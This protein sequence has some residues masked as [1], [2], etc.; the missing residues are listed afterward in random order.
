MKVA[1]SIFTVNCRVSIRP[2]SN[3][4]VENKIYRQI[5]IAFTFHYQED[6][7]MKKAQ[8][9]KALTVALCPDVFERIRAITDKREIS[10][11][12]WV[13]EAVNVALTTNQRE[14]DIM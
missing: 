1:L 12:D 14:E 2:L 8:F 4:E 5:I 6:S 10:M 13:R 11:A 3:V 7:S 9:T